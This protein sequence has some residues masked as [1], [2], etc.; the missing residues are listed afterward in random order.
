MYDCYTLGMCDHTRWLGRVRPECAYQELAE[1]RGNQIY[2]LRFADK[3]GVEPE[4]RQHRDEGF[5]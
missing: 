4:A 5:E 1:L 3:C 2:L